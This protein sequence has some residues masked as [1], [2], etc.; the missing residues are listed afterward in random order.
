MSLNSITAASTNL[1]SASKQMASQLASE[2]NTEWTLIA[3]VI[4]LIIII[5]KKDRPVTTLISFIFSGLKKVPGYL[6]TVSKKVISRLTP[7][8]LKL[9][10][11][12]DAMA[13]LTGDHNKRYQIPTYIALSDDTNLSELLTN[14]DAGHREKL[15]LKRHRKEGDKNWFIFD[16]GCIITH[17]NPSDIASDLRQYRPE[18]P[19]DGIIICINVQHLQSSDSAHIDEYAGNIYQQLWALQKEFEFVLPV[20][21]LICDLDK[22]VGF[23]A[24]WKSKNLKE[25]YDG[26]FGWSN[27]NDINQPIQKA[28]IVNAFNEI[29]IFLRQI[30]TRFIDDDTNEVSSD[31]LLFPRNLNKLSR[32]TTRFCETIFGSSSYHRSLMFRGIYFSGK[33]RESESHP[34]IP[35]FIEE[36]FAKKIFN[37]SDLAY[38]PEKK[39]FSSND[40]LRLYQYVSGFVFILMS[41][42]LVFSSIDLKLQTDN[43]VEKIETAPQLSTTE[44]SGKGVKLVKNVLNHI[45]GMDANNI[46]YVSNPWSWFSTLD[47]KLA[48]YFSDDIFGD[49]VFPSFECKVNHLLHAQINKQ[50][51]F[52]D[53]SY[54]LDGVSASLKLR[55][56]L[57]EL[58]QGTDFSKD[59]VSHKFKYLV[60][61]VFGEKLPE[62]FYQ[63]SSLYFDAIKNKRYYSINRRANVGSV[64]KANKQ[65]ACKIEPIN[66]NK[67]WDSVKQKLDQIN[68]HMLKKIAFPQRSYDLL[69]ESQSLPA[70]NSWE[71]KKDEVPNALLNYANWYSHLQNE[72]LLGHSEHNTC[73]RISSALATI[74][75]EF[76][77]KE[78]YFSSEYKDDCEENVRQQLEYDNNNNLQ[79]LYEINELAAGYSFSSR[80]RKQRDALDKVTS[81]YFIQTSVPEPFD[82]S[83]YDFFWSVEH[84]SLALQAFNEYEQFSKE[85][86]KGIHLPPKNSVSSNK[87]L[88]QSIAIRQLK[89]AMLTNVSNAR[90]KKHASYQQNNFRPVNQ[91]EAYLQSHAANFKEAMDLIISINEKFKALG[92]SD[93]SHWMLQIANRH[94]FELMKKVDELYLDNRLYAPLSRPFW[95]KHNYV[96]AL[97]GI[98]GDGQ[99]K[100]YLVAQSDRVS[101]IALNYAEPLITFVSTTKGMSTDYQ[102]FSKWEKTLIEINKKL[103]KN[104]ANSQSDLEQ[105]FT[106]E[107]MSINQSNCFQQ[108]SQLVHPQQNNIFAINQNSISNLVKSHCN[109]FRADRIASEYKNVNRLFLKMLAGNYP[110]SATANSDN[111]SPAVM[112][113][114]I[115]KYPGKSSGLAQRMEVLAW[116]NR[117]YNKA[118]KFVKKLDSSIEF[119]SYLFESTANAQGVELASD[120]NV[121]QENAKY[122]EH[123]G[124]WQFRSG[125]KI[126]HYPGAKSNI[127]WL[128]DDKVK[129]ELNWAANSPFS[130]IAK[131]GK[132]KGNRLSYDVSGVWSLLEFIQRHRSKLHDDKAFTPES[133]LLNFKADLS[134][135]N[136]A[137]SGNEIPDA[138]ALMRLTLYGLDPE[139]KQKVAIK[140]PKKFPHYAPRIPKG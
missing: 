45:S 22:V 69:I 111:V 13:L 4:L 18:R 100:D 75:N 35:K 108:S 96:Q 140:I 33:L 5:I 25:H 116:K 32:P 77:L 106:S 133:I 11:L 115:S 49:V 99:L 7:K 85:N 125:S 62:K 82:E 80:M 48:E 38:A 42:L 83:D 110:F 88:A 64:N 28:W 123:I 37:E 117:E 76:G 21:L 26:I 36:L 103:D 138:L 118:L 131:D 129:V 66:E 128:P 9:G 19:I 74:A 137:I 107:L 2:W 47:D 52:D 57:Y 56:D 39:L 84:L 78:T 12:F 91:K 46:F 135:K 6:V 127:F 10:S 1:L 114:F 112:R 16:Q 50:Q 34:Y 79:A 30:H 119:F 122:V 71:A 3:V 134:A 40:K 105:F 54:W 43:L 70:I 101:F 89:L 102:L 104:P 68:Q 124:K 113:V 15:I 53:Y 121:M 31:T 98:N 94:A 92:F 95:G 59:Q 73:K 132:T 93:G 60:E 109:S 136:N 17:P 8:R 63:N 23:E 27:P 65:I 29:A 24:F 139:T 97:F 120:F 61:N 41:T 86:Y 67:L 90:V 20:Y 130:A 87:Y 72:W 14:V 126:S 58:M 81:L 51:E 44:N 55:A